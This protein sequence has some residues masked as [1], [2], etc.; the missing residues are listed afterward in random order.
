MRNV[1]EVI[2]NNIFF[3]LGDLGR[4]SNKTGCHFS[5]NMINGRYQTAMM[6]NWWPTVITS[7]CRARLIIF[8]Y[9]H[10]QIKQAWPTKIHG[11]LFCISRQKI[12]QSYKEYIS[13]TN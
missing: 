13:G 7:W 5:C 10:T 11:L 8:C 2:C 6:E 9:Q 1:N 4:F 12:G 3:L